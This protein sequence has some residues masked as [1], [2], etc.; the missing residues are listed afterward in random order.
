MFKPVEESR[1]KTP[2]CEYMNKQLLT[3]LL[4]YAKYIS[5]ILYTGHSLSRSIFLILT[6]GVLF[7]VQYWSSDCL[8]QN[9]KL[10]IVI[11]AF[12]AD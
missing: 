8:I 4:D 2:W 10:K 7:M 12:L 6:V 1:K 3:I 5:Q 9:V 11:C